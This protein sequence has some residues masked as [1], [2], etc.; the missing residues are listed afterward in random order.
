MN[1]LQIANWHALLYTNTPT[2]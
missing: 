2:M 1:E